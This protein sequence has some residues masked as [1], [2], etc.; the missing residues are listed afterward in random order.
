MNNETDQLLQ[1]IGI[2]RPSLRDVMMMREAEASVSLDRDGRMCT[3]SG[4]TCEKCQRIYNS[5]LDACPEC[6]ACKGVEDED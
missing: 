6:E 2:S 1:A 4:V 5:E 3:Q